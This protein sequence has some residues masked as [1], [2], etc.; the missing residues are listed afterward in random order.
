MK[1]S[2]EWHKECWANRQQHYL[3][4]L[5]QER[6]LHEQNERDLAYLQEYAI[7]IERAGREG[8][9]ASSLS[10]GR[11]KEHRACQNKRRTY[12]VRS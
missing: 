6:A 4:Q 9:N 1:F 10:C 7:Q 5:E 3:R 8:R 2:L 11:R 12:E